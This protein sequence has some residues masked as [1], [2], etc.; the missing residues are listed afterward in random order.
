MNSF[1]GGVIQRGRRG[2]R[3]ASARC[4]RVMRLN[5]DRLKRF[6]RVIWLVLDSVGIGPLPDAAEYGDTD[7][8]TLGH[9]AASRPLKAPNLQRLG[10]GN[11][12]ALEHIPAAD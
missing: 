3:P 7:R 9:I 4:D 5:G 11:I 8:D 10:L 6:S 12:A 2:C 1:F